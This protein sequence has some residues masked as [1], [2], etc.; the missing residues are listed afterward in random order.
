MKRA[1]INRLPNPAITPQAYARLSQEALKQPR[2]P[3]GLKH[4]WNM[5]KEAV[6]NTN[7][8]I[9]A[10]YRETFKLLPNKAKLIALKMMQSEIEL[11]RVNEASGQHTSESQLN[12]NHNI[13]QANNSHL[14]DNVSLTNTSD[15]PWEIQRT[16][17]TLYCSTYNKDN[18]AANEYI[19]LAVEFNGRVNSPP[20]LEHTS[21]KRSSV[22]LDYTIAA[23]FLHELRVKIAGG[24]VGGTI[25][26]YFFHTHPQS[27]V[28]PI[29][30]SISVYPDGKFYTQLTGGEKSGDCAFL[31]QEFDISTQLRNDGFLGR[32]EVSFTAIPVP[33]K[34]IS[35][36]EI[37]SSI[38][39]S[40]ITKIDEPITIESS[41]ATPGATINGSS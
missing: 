6:Y 31:A 1:S 11:K 28:S 36:D 29:S 9:K 20:G 37:S 39:L 23:D 5:V 24:E 7:D 13:V 15:Y 16:I 21:G 4:I 35:L 14:Y 19:A 3:S 25:K 32:I 26:I 10:R 41:L 12:H 17:L 33:L 8:H 40:T 34:P 30:D 38:H 18:G 2:T 27:D 22:T